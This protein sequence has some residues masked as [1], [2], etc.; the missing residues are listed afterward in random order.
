LVA[1]TGTR[2]SSPAHDPTGHS[3]YACPTP[4]EYAVGAAVQREERQH[5]RKFI[6]SM[7]A[8]PDQDART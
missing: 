6:Q 4:G 1:V 5:G 2:F 3:I 8:D 7:L